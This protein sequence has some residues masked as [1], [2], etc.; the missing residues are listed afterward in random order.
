MLK[1][2]MIVNIESDGQKPDREGG[3]GELSIELEVK[4]VGLADVRAYDA[5][6]RFDHSDGRSKIELTT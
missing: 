5:R 6:L 2:K 3:Q 4:C 1:L